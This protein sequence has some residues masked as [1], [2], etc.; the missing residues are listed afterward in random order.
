ML[1]PPLSVVKKKNTSMIITLYYV[2]INIT[3]LYLYFKKKRK[4]NIKTI[5]KTHVLASV[6]DHISSVRVKSLFRPTIAFT[7]DLL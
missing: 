3:L 2:G 4:N 6:L 7:C 5:V 1:Q